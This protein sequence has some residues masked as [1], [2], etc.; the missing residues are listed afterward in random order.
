MKKWVVSPNFWQFASLE[1]LSCWL[2][3]PVEV[4]KVHYELKIEG[5][6]FPIH[7]D[8]SV[9]KKLNS[10]LHFCQY[11]MNLSQ[12]NTTTLRNY[13]IISIDCNDSGRFAIMHKALRSFQ[14]RLEVT[15]SSAFMIPCLEDGWN[16][17][18]AGRNNGF[19]CRWNLNWIIFHDKVRKQGRF[20]W[21]FANSLV[22]S[23]EV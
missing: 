2:C 7:S 6:S 19:R 9:F 21:T 17:R 5:N 20:P 12:I 18:W 22:F 3:V 16:K 23:R 1:V 4:L 15:L 8:K 13:R 11:E 14:V 10:V